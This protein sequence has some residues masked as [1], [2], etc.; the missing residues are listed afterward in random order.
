MTWND[1]VLVEALEESARVGVPLV[2]HSSAAALFRRIEG[3]MD[4]FGGGSI[5]GDRANAASSR[6]SR[7]VRMTFPSRGKLDAPRAAP[8]FI[9]RPSVSVSSIESLK[10]S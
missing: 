5:L 8:A 9:R 1:L 7:C 4:A 6:F 10:V 2:E 3:L